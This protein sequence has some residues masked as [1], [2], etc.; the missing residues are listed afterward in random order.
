M[1]YVV[2]FVADHGGVFDEGKAVQVDGDDHFCIVRLQHTTQQLTLF[3]VAVPPFRRV[4]TSGV[5]EGVD[6]EVAA[7]PVVP[8]VIGMIA[9]ETN[10]VIETPGDGVIVSVPPMAMPVVV[11]G[12]VEALL[13]DLLR[14]A[15]PYS[16]RIIRS[17]SALVVV[18]LDH[19]GEVLLGYV[20]VGELVVIANSDFHGVPHSAW[21]SQRRDT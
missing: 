5:R 6:V 15:R 7:L 18:S 21:A 10:L 2:G 14:R 1:G 20:D 9:N 4:L 3:L 12:P 19:E 13:N 11:V 17:S 16:R 8:G